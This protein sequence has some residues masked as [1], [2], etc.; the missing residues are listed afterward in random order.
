VTSPSAD[1]TRAASATSSRPCGA[2]ITARAPF[3]EA[4]PLSARLARLHGAR[5]HG[6]GLHGLVFTALVF[7]VLVFTVL[8]LTVLA[9]TAAHISAKLYA[10]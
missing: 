5:L 8:M 9:F 10:V 1:S 4:G 2:G 7:T 6:A 3:R